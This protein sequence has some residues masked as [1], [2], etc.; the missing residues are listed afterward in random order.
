MTEGLALDSIGVETD[1]RGFIPVDEHY[2]TSVEGVWAIGDVIPGPMLAHLAE[3]EG[4][5]AAEAMAGQPG[6]V[7]YEAVPNVIYTHPEIASLG[8][9]T[10]ELDEA[11]VPYRVGKFPLMA[12]GRAKALAA[13]D[14]FVKI[15]AH[16]ETDRIL[17]ASII[18]ARAGDLIAE[19]A[20]AV[21]FSAS[22][23]DIARSIHAHP[24]LAETVKEAAL[25]VLGRVINF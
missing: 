9:T 5:C 14:G 10:T 8:K 21:E 15:I 20:V 16:A 22:S 18:G 2:K 12:N 11:G 23:E 24:T 6:H 25:D 4:V 3:H 17:G 13:T 19:L 1:R 7:N